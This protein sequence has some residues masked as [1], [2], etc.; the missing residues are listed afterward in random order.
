MTVSVMLW[1]A[2]FSVCTLTAGSFF[3]NAQYI[4]APSRA[5]PM[6]LKT[7]SF[8]RPL[9]RG[10]GATACGGKIGGVS[11]RRACLNGAE[12]SSA[13]IV[14]AMAIGSVDKINFLRIPVEGVISCQFLF[15]KHYYETRHRRPCRS[16]GHNPVEPGRN[17]LC[18]RASLPDRVTRRGLRWRWCNR[19]PLFVGRNDLHRTFPKKPLTGLSMSA[20]AQPVN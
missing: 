4:A 20:A 17:H 10:L 8:L 16:P 11:T 14:F 15:R 9:R 1:R 12:M 18:Q 19:M 7:M 13:G 5:T 2:T 3:R 6:R